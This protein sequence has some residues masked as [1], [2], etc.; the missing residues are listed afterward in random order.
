[1]QEYFTNTGRGDLIMFFESYNS[2][3]YS[4]TLVPDIFI[5]EYMPSMNSDHVKVYIYCL[6]LNKYNKHATAEE[7]SKK[8]EID[9]NRVKD[10]LTYLENVGVISRRDKSITIIDLKE[11]E[12][13][14]IYRLKATSTPEEAALSSERNKK[15]NR[16][17]SAINNTFFQGV[18]SPSWYTDIDAWFDKYKFEEDVMYALFQH[19][20]DHKG[21][22]KQYIAK[23]ADNWYSKNIK[24]SFDLDRY[25]IEYQK[26]K[27]IRLK[28][29]KRLKR[30]DFLTEYEEEY[31]EKWIMNYNYGF[32]IIELA[33]KKTTAISTPN[34]EYI[35][36]ILTDWYK[37]GLRSKDEIIIYEKSRRQ[38]MAK[39]KPKQQ[40]A[41]PQHAN[42]EQR[43]Y[44]KDYF[45]NLYEEV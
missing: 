37:N 41:I 28:I 34:F 18:M 5:T 27:D 21:L 26:L 10:A 20:Y 22:S 43:K 14:K 29:V 12:I 2:I 15:R 24:N 32:D 3:L 4:D 11:K 1:M 38:A 8:L 30:K 35:N 19:C 23:V 17:I 25:F 45:N 36:K 31:I 9:I 13:N 42:F 39:N 6:F 16:I 40:P 33:L 7:L 44:D